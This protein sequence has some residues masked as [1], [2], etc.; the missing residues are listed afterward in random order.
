MSYMYI[1]VYTRRNIYSVYTAYIQ[2]VC[3]YIY[4][5]MCV[6]TFMYIYIY[7][8]I[9]SLGHGREQLVEGIPL[10][11]TMAP[12]RSHNDEATITQRAP[13]CGAEDI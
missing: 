8:Y 2:C 6:Y 3:I 9:V 4:I 7:V 12:W 10:P 5:Y 11:S 13:F 1:I